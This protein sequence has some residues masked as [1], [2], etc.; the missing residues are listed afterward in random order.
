MNSGNVKYGI[1]G[2]VVGGIVFGAMMGM[3]GMLSMIGQMVDSYLK[4]LKQ[5]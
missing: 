2:G 3:M 5:K 4:D 1:V